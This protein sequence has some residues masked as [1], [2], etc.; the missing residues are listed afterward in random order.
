MVTPN[1]RRTEQYQRRK[2]GNTFSPATAKLRQVLR[3]EPRGS[4][5]LTR[6]SLLLSAELS[7]EQLC[8]RA[9][10]SGDD[11]CSTGMLSIP[12]D[13]K[14]PQLGA[15]LARLAELCRSQKI[16][17]PSLTYSPSP[18]CTDLLVRGRAKPSPRRSAAELSHMG[19][20]FICP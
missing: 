17:L 20:F 16:H 15:F 3:R 5:T 7:A 1:V 12:R 2:S 14:M 6:I 18:M 13:E 19:K 9:V 4:T 11:H 10:R 8:Y